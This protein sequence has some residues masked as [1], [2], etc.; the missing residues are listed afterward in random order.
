MTKIDTSLRGIGV[1]VLG[2]AG[3]TAAIT[4]AVPASAADKA[5]GTYVTGDFHNHTTC[6]DGTVSLK[7]LV[8]KSVN[9]FGLD[10]FAQAGHGGNSPR[11]CTLAE[12]PFEP[13]K[14][15][16]NLTV[17]PTIPSSGQ[18][19]GDGKG[20]NQLWI[21]TLPG[22][23]ADIKGDSVLS[24]GVRSMWRWQMIQEYVYPV[25]EQESRARNKPIFVGLE[26]NV[27]GHEHTSMSILDGQLPDSGT[28]NASALAQFEYCFDRSDTDTSRGGANQ[29][30]CSVPGSANNGLVDPAAKKIKVAAGTGSGTAGHVKTVEGVKW[31]GAKFPNTSYYVPAHL[32]RP[33]SFNPNGN[34]GFNIEHLRD[35]NNA[36][37]TVAFGFET[38]PGHQA[39]NPRGEY[40][41]TAA[42]GGTYGGTGIYGARIGGVWDTLLGEGRNWFFFASSDYHNR[43]IFGPD[44]RETTSDFF[45]GEYTKDYVLARTGGAKLTTQAIVDG[46]RSGNSF[47]VT[48]DLIDRLTYVACV[49]HPTLPAKAAEAA[50]EATAKAAFNGNRAVRMDGCATMGEKLVV[51]QGSDVLVAIIVRDPQGANNSPYAFPNPSLLQVGVSQPL[52]MPVLDHVDVIT[53]KV[54]GYV[55]PGDTAY[56]GVEGSAAATNPTAAVV[57]TYNA[58]NWTAGTNGTRTM[59]YRIRTVKDSQYVRLRGTNLPPAVPY[60]TDTNGNPLLD[61]NALGKIPC[62]DA[63]CPAHMAV[64]NGQKMASSDVA[65]WSDLWFYSN[66]IFIEVAGGVQVA[67]IK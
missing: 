17:P 30:D 28:G 10:W 60:E 16:L 50:L 52:N 33:G 36:A 6:S 27:P 54:T 21:N 51:P 59:I 48:G 46:L 62:T 19:S 12:D 67:G 41:P 31:M 65:A 53:G 58:S 61:A 39:R 56:A 55:K 40:S 7:K 29:W 5:A 14:P 18:A 45:P 26:Q 11:N 4:G 49:A 35:F 57:K 2:V 37:P 3:L 8:D 25:I 15:A 32:E 34:N 44:Q 66:P 13:V 63:A 23:A 9:T 20:P 42:G 24:S 64:V 47:V 43:G 22:G 1:T 38:M